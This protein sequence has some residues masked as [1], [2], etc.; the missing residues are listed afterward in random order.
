[1]VIVK[2]G[3]PPYFFK[4]GKT[5]KLE[6]LFIAKENKLYKIE[7]DSLFDLTNLKTYELKWS[8]LELEEESYNEELLANLREQLKNLEISNTFAILIPVVDKPL[9]TPEQF[10][11]FANAYNHAARRIK[12][13]ISLVGIELPK[14]LTAQGFGEDSEYQNFVGLLTKKHSHYVYFSKQKDVPSQVVIL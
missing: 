9:Q 7:D 5:M 1:M 2:F 8:E 4:L 6:P 11:L 12:D 3:V 10:E 13:C 14:E